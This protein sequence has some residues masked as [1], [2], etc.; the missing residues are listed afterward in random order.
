MEPVDESDL[1]WSERDHGETRFR[2]KQLGEAAGSEALG[3]SLYEL[4]AGARS[5]P[6]HYHTANEEAIFVL[7]GTGTIRLD[8]DEY[9]LGEGDYVPLPANE[10]GGHRVINDGEE[11]LRYLAISTMNEPDVTVYPDSEKLGVFVG[12]PPGSR[13]DRSL[14]GYYRIDDD[15]SYWEDED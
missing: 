13:D 7:S 6:Y 9:D 5:W 4:P 1:E 14:Y 11:T 10:T 2:R 3:C 15:V 12:A 8:G